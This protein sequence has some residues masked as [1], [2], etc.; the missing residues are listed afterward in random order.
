LT[1]AWLRGEPVVVAGPRPRTYAELL[2]LF[3]RLTGRDVGYQQ[4]P[5]EQVRQT[6][7]ADLAAMTELF[8]RDGFTAAPSPVL[9]DLNLVPGPVDDYLTTA[10][11]RPAPAPAADV[12]PAGES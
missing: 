11:N 9:H 7:G 1:T 4:I 3:S 12:H 10:W 5:L 8:N 2:S 6:F